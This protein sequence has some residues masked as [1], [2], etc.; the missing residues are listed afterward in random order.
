MLKVPYWGHSSIITWSTGNHRKVVPK[1]D[2]IQLF[3]VR[4]EFDLC[5][6]SDFILV[7]SFERFWRLL[8]YF[9]IIFDH[10]ESSFFQKLLFGLLDILDWKFPNFIVF[11]FEEAVSVVLESD[12][13]W[14]DVDLVF[15]GWKGNQD[16]LLSGR[17]VDF[18]G[19]IL[20]DQNNS[21]FGVF[22]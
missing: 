14:G 13:L 4:F 22:V 21:P 1:T 11:G 9:G 8:Q 6:L 7:E 3:K 2:L 18:A 20:I 19:I 10:N 16:W 17:S 15:F 12:F 5:L